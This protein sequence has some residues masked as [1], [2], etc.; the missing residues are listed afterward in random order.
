MCNLMVTLGSVQFHF[1]VR[2]THVTS[3]DDLGQVRLGPC[4]RETIVCIN[5]EDFH[6]FH[7][8]FHTLLFWFKK[9]VGLIKPH[10]LF[11]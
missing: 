9:C 4:P 6:N 7:F 2:A 5:C 1:G 11:C 3:T 10:P 8:V